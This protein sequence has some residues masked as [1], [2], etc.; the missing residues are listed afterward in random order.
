M[1]IAKSKPGVLRVVPLGGVGE[2]GGNSMIFEYGDDAI[3]IDCG[4]MIPDAEM[5]GID[6]VIPDFGYVYE[7]KKNVRAIVITHG[8]EDHI[9]AL[10]YIIPR[11]NVP[12]YGTKLTLGLIRARLQEHGLDKTADLRLV[13]PR[14]ELELGAFQLKF[15]HVCHSIP[16]GVGIAIKTPIGTVV[17]SG[18]YKFDQTPVDGIGPDFHT[19]GE[20]GGEGVLALFADSTY[21]DRP[22]Y[23]P[24]ERTIYDSFES[25]FAEAPGRVIVST[26]AS[27]ISR[28]QQVLD[29]SADFGRKV[30]VV[31]R[32]MENNV[33]IAID[34]GYLKPPDGIFIEIGDIDHFRSEE[35]TIVCTGS[36]GEPTSALVRM[37]NRDHRTI[38]IQPD[39]TVILSA[40][41][42]P[43][44]EE[45]VNRT[46]DRLF[47]QGANVID[48]KASPIHVSGHGSQEEIKLLLG[49][50]RPTYLV[51]IHGEYRHL[52]HH[53]R[54]ANSVGIPKD[55]VLIAESGDVI[56]FTATSGKIVDRVAMG[57]VFVDGLGVGDVGTEVLRD[58]RRLAGDGILIAAITVDRH[59]GML[60]D[61]PDLISRGF[62]Y[63]PES[64]DILDR[65]KKLLI[66]TLESEVSAEPD[67]TYL[68]SKVRNTLGRHLYAETRRRPMIISVVTEV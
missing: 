6:L 12:I 20:L 62:V 9:G 49:M 10:P 33:P 40:S 56:E 64:G 23:T 5:L 26:F 54:V 47:R 1:T 63:E 46:I 50:L 8:H 31:G 67:W 21:A 57:Y 55:N 34:L 27:L 42:I 48:E 13:E 60:I 2:I 14:Q 61:E 16:D 3:I 11:L 29:V 43:G 25:A 58:R 18:D 51:P 66:K 15:F 37:A 19:L 22:G 24:S 65:A 53:A 68:K 28:I 41:P 59:T 35:L 44:N 36:Q 30:V 45:P 7:R 17:H 52:V 39:D 38:E 4:V 32:S